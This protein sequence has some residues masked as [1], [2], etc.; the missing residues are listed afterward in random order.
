LHCSHIV[1]KHVNCCINLLSLGT[2]QNLK[3]LNGDF[4]SRNQNS[5]LISYY[6]N[7]Q[8]KALTFNSLKTFVSPF[9]RR[10]TNDLLCS[11]EMSEFALLFINDEALFLEE[12]RATV[13]AINCG[14]SIKLKE[15][16]YN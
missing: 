5:D 2:T 14:L 10:L 7:I 15:V 12:R 16:S 6:K 1:L 3:Y 8:M 9:I 13:L 4:V 11:A